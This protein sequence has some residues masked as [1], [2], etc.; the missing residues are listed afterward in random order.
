MK[1][2]IAAVAL[3]ATLGAALPAEAASVNGYFRSNG[4][5]VAP[6]QRSVPDGYRFNNYS[7][8]GNTNP[9]TGQRGYRSPAYQLP[10]MPRMPRMPR[11][12]W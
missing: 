10:S 5:Y 3:T 8:L 7:T 6:Y 2:I 1:G 4:T 12:R 11:V 9:Y